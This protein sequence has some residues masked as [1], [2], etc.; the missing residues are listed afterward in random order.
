M[1]KDIED[2]S[3]L[4]NDYETIK[5]NYHFLNSE[6]YEMNKL[7]SKIKEIL[8]K[9]NEN[10]PEL[11]ELAT[12][13]PAIINFLPPEKLKVVKE[14]IAKKQE[15]QSDKKFYSYDGQAFST[16]EEAIARNNEITMEITPKQSR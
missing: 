5:G 7:E 8:A 15:V 11:I 1:E 12:I 6:L 13:N 3:F 9:Y 14:A 16:M 2:L 10:L 4:I